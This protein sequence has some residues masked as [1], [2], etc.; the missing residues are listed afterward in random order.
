MF[1]C[2]S[3]LWYSILF[4]ATAAV[5]P[6]RADEKPAAVAQPQKLK[7]SRVIGDATLRP[8]GAAKIDITPTHPVLLSGYVGRKQEL[9]LEV[10][11]R[12]H[13]RAIAIGSDE[14][15][16]CVLIAVDNLGVSADTHRA[17]AAALEAKRGI[18]R[19]HLTINASHTHSAPMLTG[20][21]S[22]IFA[23]DLTF[24]QQLMMDRYT[25]HLAEL[26]VRVA[27]DAL[28]KRVPCRLD[29]GKTSTDFAINRR[30]A[31]IV[32]HSVPVLRA[33]DAQGTIRALVTNYA[34]HTV[35]APGD[36]S[37][38]GDW[39]GYAA[40][41]L[42][43]EIPDSVVLVLAGCGADQNP[44][45]VGSVEVAKSQG[46]MLAEAIAML[47]G[48]TL[49]PVSG[50]LESQFDEIELRLAKAY[51]KEEWAKR[52]KEQGIIGYH[53]QKNLA[54]LERGETLPD[55]IIYPVQTW[56]FGHDLAAVFLAGEV[57][58]DYT[59]LIGDKHDYSRMWI[60]GYSN[61]APCYIPSE[62]V[63][64]EGGYEGGDAMV[65]Y[66][67]PRP[68][69]PGL[70]K[71]IVDT[72][73]AQLAGFGKPSNT[74]KTGGTRALSPWQSIARMQ[75]PN[76]LRIEV[77]AAE[78][79]VVDPVAIDFGHDG[80]LWVAEMHDY[81]EGID[82]KFK[83]GG[84]IKYLEDTNQDGTYDK[85]TTFLE[86][87]AF[88]TGVKVWRK[89]VLVCTAP[90]VLYAEDTNGDGRADIVRK[91]LSGFSTENQQGR[92]NSLSLGLD[93]WIYGAAGIFGG[94]VHS[95]DGKPVDA[96]FR[97]FRFQPDAGVVE[98][99]SGRTQQGR[100]RDDWGNWFGCDSGTLIY[101]LPLTEHYYLRNSV[102][103][104]PM[105][106]L[107]IAASNQLFPTGKLVQFALSGPP[108]LPTSAC[109]LGIYRDNLLGEEFEQSAFIC[110]P[111]NQLIH[112]M[113]LEPKGISYVARRA[114]SEQDH[115][116]LSSTDNW[117]RP[118]QT[119]TGPDG[120]LYIVDM[121]RYLIE[122]PVWLTPEARASIDAR[123]G[124]Q[125]GRIYRIVPKTG[126]LRSIH[127]LSQMS[128]PDVVATLDSPNG[129]TRD[130]VHLELL[131]RA[132]NSA[133]EPLAKL[134]KSAKLPQVRLQANCVLD[135][136]SSLSIDAVLSALKDAAPGVR[137]QATRHAEKFAAA[138]TPPTDALIGLVND[139]DAQVRMQLAYSLGQFD[140]PRVG[141]AL[142][143]LMQKAGGDAHA[144]S[145]A[146]SSLT[147]KNVDQAVSAFF[148]HHFN[149]TDADAF[150]MNLLSIATKIGSEKTIAVAL[151]GLLRA[152]NGRFAIWQFKATSEL[153]RELGQ[154]KYQ[155]SSE[156]TQ[157]LKRMIV[158]ARALTDDE[159]ADEP[160]RIAAMGILSLS[161]DNEDLARLMDRLSPLKPLSIQHAA[162]LSL[163]AIDSQAAMDR[164][165]ETFPYLTPAAQITI[166]D[167]T[168]AQERLTR[169]L[170]TR[171]SAETIPRGVIDATRKLALT[172][173]PQEE[174][175]LSAQKLFAGA[176]SEEIAVLLKRFAA[177]D[178]DLGDPVAGRVAFQKHCAACHQVESIG[179]AVGPDLAALTDKSTAAMVTAI[180]DPNAT[181]DRRYAT[182]TAITSAG[183]VFTGIMASESASSITL[184]AQ[185]GKEQTILRKD[186]DGPD[187]L[188]NTGQSLMP[189]GLVK[190]IDLETMQDLLAFLATSSIPPHGRFE[191]IKRMTELL[192][193]IKVGSADE[194]L[195][196]PELWE[197]AIAAGRRNDAKEIV[198]ILDLS[199]PR[200]DRPLTLWQAVVIGGGIINGISEIGVWPNRRISE[201][202]SDDSKLSMRWQRAQLLAT[203]MAADKSVLSGFRYD[204]IRLMAMRPFGTIRSQ[205]GAYL[206]DNTDLDVRQAAVSGLADIAHPDAAALLVAAC[207]DLS[208]ELR[209]LALAGILRTTDGAN[210]LLTSLESQEL[211]IE[212]IGEEFRK[213]LLGHEDHSVQARARQ[214]FAK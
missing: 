175:R 1:S 34:C 160:T 24:E 214:L 171:I 210:R 83:P 197:I 194:R 108:G 118:V 178:I 142:L 121:Y 65:W 127:N 100:L 17:V 156:Q 55:S 8:V 137:L 164:L 28:S 7:I 141:E 140:D 183:Q 143:G 133:V 134:A 52:A 139:D 16:P 167:E 107:T 49:K 113:K 181:V 213:K 149:T 57:V 94:T 37:M 60:S 145:A 23:R 68:F 211:P 98:A 36:V 93:N 73:E 110:E 6:V 43:S 21:A 198:A 88:P 82:G 208:P 67:K 192:T 30:V 9:A 111:V 15:K 97:D 86:D 70:E 101:H 212:I 117:F 64:R 115:E 20:V 42:E 135:G 147:I 58:V 132:D 75:I 95:P 63:L 47:P 25:E 205:L 209:E 177:T 172:N 27:E 146:L 19:S 72:V 96:Q 193:A 10:T 151:D 59:K 131:W 138:A 153:L 84:R 169:E 11:Q 186:L 190:E 204:A 103:A 191:S 123:A 185:E 61:D 56:T 126:N 155:L 112:R 180:V 41:E 129:P 4:I 150:G 154:R 170:L 176:T 69:A 18:P 173:H 206:L 163:A 104:A 195:K 71:K 207:R 87:V 199:L 159:S 74:A 120:A 48:E 13:A 89:G 106:N 122:H 119:V 196:I 90:D 158:A 203:S 39:S 29:F 124:D 116:F 105:S 144:K 184:K 187:A 45:K 162:I 168:M 174:I 200:G 179:R 85:A 114:Q 102:V 38:S 165:F 125:Q 76:H 32:D 182:Y 80:K 166:L 81:P 62:R 99:V 14:D 188:K 26:L 109:G 44:R 91:S 148:K 12:L 152:E 92:V 157:S 33:T 54:R 40:E 51:T 46:H 3:F 161:G 77:V 136:L 2:N 5:T 202:L 22:N 128:T 79:H 35:A 53:A 66:D 50:K 201:L 31:P 189:Q 78:P 130:M